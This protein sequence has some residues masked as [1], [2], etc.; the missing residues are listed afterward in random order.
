MAILS[1]GYFCNQVTLQ[2]ARKIDKGGFTF[3]RLPRDVKKKKPE[4]YIYVKKV[5]VDICYMQEDPSEKTLSAFYTAWPDNLVFPAARFLSVHLRG[6]VIR[7]ETADDNGENEMLD[8]IAQRIP[9]SIPMLQRA[10]IVYDL[11]RMYRRE[12]SGM[13]VAEL[14]MD[15][16]FPAVFQ[17]VKSLEFRAT[18]IRLDSK[19]VFMQNCSGFTN[20]QFSCQGNVGLFHRI[21][22]ISAPILEALDIVNFRCED[23][24]SLFYHDEGQPMTYP[25]LQK[26]KF[27][28]I[29]FVE[30][31]DIISLDETIVP[32]P[33]L[34]HLSWPTAY[35][36]ADDTVFRGNSATLE[37]LNITLDTNLVNVLDKYKVFSSGKYSKLRHISVANSSSIQVELMGFA[38]FV[39][40]AISLI[41]PATKSFKLV[42]YNPRQ[43]LT[44]LIPTSI[45]AENIQV[46]DLSAT[47]LVLLDMLDLIKLLPNMTDFTCIPG[48]IGSEM[49]KKRGS[50]LQGLEAEYYPLSHRLRCWVVSHTNS[51]PLRSIALSSLALAILC[52]NFTFAALPHEKRKLYNFELHKITT[53][54]GYDK[55]TEKIKRLCY[56]D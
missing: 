8:W 17:R 10:S 50:P 2:V 30:D 31:Q 44:D 13:V 25:K 55:Y 12:S 23:L 42:D 38:S 14:K 54:G 47:K 35:T 5:I 41:S 28:F 53:G 52:S 49:G 3:T 33:A 19:C 18:P 9:T 6:N 43:P 46:L 4:L 51:I 20:L 16:L 1:L 36:F 40:Y 29:T 32:F 39:S 15:N 21:L 24:R 37:Y 34:T 45:F 56:F 7:T 22:E 27:H 26:L 11:V 48:G